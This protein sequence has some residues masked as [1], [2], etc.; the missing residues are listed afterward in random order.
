[1]PKTRARSREE[2]DAAI[3]KAL[4]HP[5]RQRI[6][7]EL[8]NAGV[9]S[10]S[11]LADALEKPL[12]DVSYHMKVLRKL[13]CVDLVR[14]EP[15]RGALKH[16][17]RPTARAWLDDEQWSRLPLT[18]RRQ[19]MRR[20]LAD[21]FDDAVAAAEDG[22]FDDPKVHV[23]RM[24]LNLDEQGWNEMAD[25]LVGVLEAAG[26][27]QAE[28]AARAGER[29]TVPDIGSE[30]GIMHFRGRAPASAKKRRRS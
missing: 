14:T 30:L 10:P 1:M 5:L 24:P 26:R 21:L 15:V 6:L 9:L 12:G 16:F 17:Y 22:G 2:A 3:L 13:G 18:F 19:T 28:S 20:T 8:D 25:V 27:I 23:S 7:Q 4:S 29:D 11:Q